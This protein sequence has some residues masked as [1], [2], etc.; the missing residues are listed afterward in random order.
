MSIIIKEKILP[1]KVKV[2][3]VKDTFLDHNLTIKFNNY[4]AILDTEHNLF[5]MQHLLEHA[6]FH[7]FKD[8]NLDY[9]AQTAVH[10]MAL[11]LNLPKDISKGLFYLKN[12]LFKNNDLSTINLARDLLNREIQMFINELHSEYKYRDV[13][14]I[15]WDLQYFLLNNGQCHYMGGN[16]ESFKERTEDI[17]KY[18]A[19]PYPI[20]PQDIVIMLGESK[21]K[22]YQDIVDIFSQLKPISSRNYEKIFYKPESF[23]NKLVQINNGN[24]NY[25]SFILDGNTYRDTE[26]L[27]YMTS[28]YP[29]MS[30]NRSLNNEIFVNFGF[31]E[32]GELYNFYSMLE[33]RSMN[34]FSLE[35]NN[36]PV[37][38]FLEEMRLD[39][40]SK[41]MLSFFTNRHTYGEVYKMHENRITNFFDTIFKLF[42]KKNFVVNVTKNYLENSM[43]NM[44]EKYFTNPVRFNIDYFGNNFN[45]FDFYLNM[46][47]GTCVHKKTENISYLHKNN[48]YLSCGKDLSASKCQYSKNNFQLRKRNSFSTYLYAI[49]SFIISPNFCSLEK[50]MNSP[51]TVVPKKN[52]DCSIDIKNETYKI[53]TEYDFLVAAIKVKSRQK[54]E[55]IRISNNIQEQLKNQGYCY[56]LHFDISDFHDNSV[57][58]FHAITEPKYYNP[59]LNILSANLI[60]NKISNNGKMCRILSY[61]I[62]DNKEPIDIKSLEKNIKITI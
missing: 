6:I 3:I 33:S 56:F 49:K 28:L 26:F 44:Q 8:L 55:V 11:Q 31:N 22:Y 47:S 30:F 9:N 37:T 35:K 2:L 45:L 39:E 1:N 16:L 40:Y 48:V 27:H 14:N 10:Y 62:K 61:G 52:L 25:I 58:M 50:L 57:F 15:P 12:W 4:G 17:R 20:A 18:L 13:L 21:A 19:S 42:D 29:F 46:K 24:T 38:F 41:N 34:F 59:I 54:S 5:G 43:T 36:D 51:N 7:N 60:S 32:I 23:Y 53:K